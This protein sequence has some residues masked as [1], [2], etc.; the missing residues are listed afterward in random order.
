M[1]EFTTVHLVGALLPPALLDRIAADPQLPDAVR[2]YH[3]AAGETPREAANRAW[4]YLQ[5]VWSSFTAVRATRP[6]ADPM[7]GLTRDRWLQVLLRELGYGR[8]ATTPAGGLAAGDRSFA[9]THLW[10]RTPM[11]L[12]GWGVELDRRTPGVAGA[13]ER[14]PHA[15]L[16]EY[17]NRSEEHLW[18]V[19]SNGRVLRL[20]RDSTSLS[21]QSYLE[22]DLQ[23]MFDG[24]VF[25]DFL[26]LFLL[27][28]QSRVEILT[29]DGAGAATEC[30]LERWRTAAIESGTRAKEQLR[31]GVQ[32]AITALGTGF[33]THPEGADLNRRIAGR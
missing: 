24:E 2:D 1:T 22:F 32:A 12:L 20:L 15:L 27:L 7:V 8:V 19:V 23:A 25:S 14:A 28:H 21:G 5:G 31:D 26:L 13:A 11:H 16:Q 4:T 3:L 29:E 10:E 30:W 6:A 18:G 17:L 9:V 33:L